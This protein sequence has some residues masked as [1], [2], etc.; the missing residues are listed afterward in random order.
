MDSWPLLSNNHFSN[1]IRTDHTKELQS[2]RQASYQFGRKGLICT[3]RAK[4]NITAISLQLASDTGQQYS[5]QECDSGMQCPRVNAATC[6]CLTGMIRMTCSISTLTY[7]Q[8]Q[9]VHCSSINQKIFY[10]HQEKNAIV[11]V[12]S[13]V[14]FLKLFTEH[15]LQLPW[16]KELQQIGGHKLKA[17]TILLAIVCRLGINI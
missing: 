8:P 4:I 2:K 6:Q 14:C 12:K 3:M 11:Y 7:R 16:S 9:A 10:M 13:A 17:S 5:S 1:P 15:S